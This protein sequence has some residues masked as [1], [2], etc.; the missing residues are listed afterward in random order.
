M[1]T[2]IILSF[3][4]GV[5]TVLAPCVL[6]LLPIIIGSSVSGKD[7]SK[8]YLVTLG[9]VVSITIFTIL[10][11]A[12]TLL[13]TIDQNIWKYIS[14]G[15]V[16]FFGMI[17]LFPDLW[18]RL[19]GRF[20]LTSKSDQILEKA[21]NK[22]SIFGSLLIGAALG[23]VFA[24]CS[25]TYSLII[26]TV[27]PVNFYEGVFYIIIYSL[28]L[29]SVMLGIALFGRRLINK[30]KLFANPNGWFKKGLGILFIIVGI[31]VITGLDKSLESFVIN[32]SSFD[33]TKLETRLLEIFRK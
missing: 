28:G 16:L 33:I 8:P 17:Y 27:L 32:S 2:L 3:I 25:P 31:M 19:I 14:G 20:N 24:S 7:K 11:K 15:I 5:L 23:P 29:A 26:A 13:I 10:L 22:K 9:L 18:D 1:L 30:L 21:S 4:S 6:P 12:S